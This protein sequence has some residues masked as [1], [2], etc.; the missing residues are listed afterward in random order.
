MDEKPWKPLIL[1][2][3]RI[4]FRFRVGKDLSYQFQWTDLKNIYEEKLTTEEIVSRWSLLNKA[5]ETE[6]DGQ[7]E[8][9]EFGLRT[10]SCVQEK[11]GT[12]EIEFIDAELEVPLKWI[13][14]CQRLES[15][16]FS[17]QIVLPILMVMNYEKDVNVSNFKLLC[18]HFV[19]SYL[20]LN[21]LK[22]P[23]LRKKESFCNF[24]LKFLR[25]Q[26]VLAILF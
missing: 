3:K 26:P 11:E 25:V 24:G 10:P 5:V 16:S 15:D 13:F 12:V 23:N 4:L 6:L 19:L 9:I 1:N 22:T 2:E 14:K 17:T 20:V 7:I 18:R 21:L 8:A